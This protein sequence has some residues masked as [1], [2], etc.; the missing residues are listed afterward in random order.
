MEY[1]V[2]FG[3]DHG[4]QENYAQES[5]PLLTWGLSIIAPLTLGN[6]F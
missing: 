6:V 5:G 2:P 3:K 4:V 1:H